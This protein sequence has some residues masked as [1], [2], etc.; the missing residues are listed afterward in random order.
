[1]QSFKLDRSVASVY[2][3]TPMRTAEICGKKMCAQLRLGIYVCK[4]QLMSV[5]LVSDCRRLAALYM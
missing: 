4:T 5:K 2:G 3:H 1:M